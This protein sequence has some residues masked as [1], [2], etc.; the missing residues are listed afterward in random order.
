MSLALYQVDA[1]GSGPFTGNPAGVCILPG[2]ADAGWMQSIAAEM[3]L[4]ET[5]FLHPESGGYRLRWFTPATEVKLCGHATLASAHVLWEQAYLAPGDTAVF[6]TLSGRLT[7]SRDG[8]LIALDFPSDPPAEA[9]LPAELA[10]SLGITPSYTGMSGF[11]YVV[12]VDSAETVRR[13][14]PDFNLLRKIPVTGVMVTGASDMEGYDFISR[15][16]AAGAGINED[17]ATGA[18][19]CCLAPYWAKK[20]GISELTAYQASARGGVLRVRVE[21]DRVILA[22]NAVTVFK[23]DLLV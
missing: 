11:G 12:E 5:A 20:L 22:G 1:F 2:P 13:L 14:E 6:H 4:S 3:N 17:P 15:C 16:F 19:H 10:A 18:A 21:G 8:D 7:A 9:D 23:L